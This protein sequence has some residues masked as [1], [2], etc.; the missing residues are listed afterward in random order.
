MAELLTRIGWSHRFFA[1]KVG[2][3]EKTV[4]RWCYGKENPVAMEYL[5]QIARILGV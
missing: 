5:R 1:N 2:V 4:G 3:D